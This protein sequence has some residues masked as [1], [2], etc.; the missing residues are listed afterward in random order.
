MTKSQILRWR[1]FMLFLHSGVGG[2]CAG[3]M[4]M[5]LINSRNEA[6]LLMAVCF[7][8]NI[9]CIWAWAIK[10]PKLLEEDG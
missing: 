5:H 6:A 8:A 2:M 4:L 7:A 1:P 9:G 10:I 3:M